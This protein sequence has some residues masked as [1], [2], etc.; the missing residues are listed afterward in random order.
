[1]G[2]WKPPLCRVIVA[3][4][5]AM[6][7]RGLL[8]ATTLVV[9][10]GCEGSSSRDQAPETMLT[11]PVSFKL[12]SAW[13]SS[14]PVLGE[15]PIRFADEVARRSDGKTRFQFYEPGDLAPAIEVLDAVASGKAEAGFTTPGYSVGDEAAFA[16]FAA[17][18]FGP[19]MENYWEWMQS[20]GGRA[21]LEQLYRP[22]NVMP[23]PCGYSGT[24]GFGWFRTPINGPEDLRGV[25]MRF[26]GL[27]ARVMQKLGVST[28][29]L[30]GG[31]LYP[32]LEKGVIDAA[33]FS[34]PYLDRH[35][36]LA[37]VAK[38]YYYP[39][40]QQRATMMNVII[41]LDTWNA[42]PR[43]RQALI[44]AACEDNVHYS[45]RKQPEQVAEGLRDI[46]SQG[47][48]VRAP[49]ASV[50]AAARSA[51]QEVLKEQSRQSTRFRDIYATLQP[52]L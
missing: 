8:L 37:P 46:A 39:G 3:L 12:A 14:I 6:G 30:A 10:A 4:E 41:N 9:L 35:Y 45:I 22:Y 33:E 21:A 29:I 18:P 26:L 51:W 13:G 2:E 49:P 15:L 5:W 1:M 20:G 16:L 31:D 11:G 24:E 52:Y 27:G 48:I 42:L 23:I 44:T 19:S 34:T 7:W 50:V 43:E 36:G 47:A 38:Y 17:V 28:Q 32:A 40:W 25:K